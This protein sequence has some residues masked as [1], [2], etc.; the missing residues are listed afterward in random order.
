M[1][2]YTFGNDFRIGFLVVLVYGKYGSVNVCTWTMDNGR[3]T[4]DNGQWTMD[5]GQ[6]T[7][8]NGKYGRDGYDGCEISKAAM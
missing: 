6:W 8:D 1:D 5:N 4:M 7:M 2:I 3:W